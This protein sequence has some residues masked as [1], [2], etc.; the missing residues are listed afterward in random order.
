MREESR[1][2]L[3]SIPQTHACYEGH[4]P[5][6]PLVPGA[7]MIQWL[8]ELIQKEFPGVTL[9]SLKSMKFINP[10]RPGNQCEVLLNLQVGKLKVN[11]L[12]GGQSSLQGLFLVD[13]K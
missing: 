9:R 1:K 5:G 2:L 7:L 8:A 4:F 12:I 13:G 6:D 11:C 3:L 10:I